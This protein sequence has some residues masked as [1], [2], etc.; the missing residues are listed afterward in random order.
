MNEP[1]LIAA[2]SAILREPQHW[3]TEI[4]NK[5]TK[6]ELAAKLNGR[7]YGDEMTRDEE[8]LAH[9]SGLL[10]FGA[11]D[12]L[13]EFR[14]LFND[15][16]GAYICTKY[17]LDSIGLLPEWDDVKDDEDQAE[18]YFKRKGQGKL[19]TAEWCGGDGKPAWTF[20]TG[21]PHAEFTIMDTGYKYCVGLV[22][23]REDLEP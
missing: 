5:I 10:V 8:K 20:A 21:I 9:D 7:Q 13:T 15:E 3:T 23:S 4:M 12:E 1:H 17:R 22:I 6:E 11:S 16:A 14:G 2:A 18:E 19:I